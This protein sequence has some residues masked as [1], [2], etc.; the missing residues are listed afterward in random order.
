MSQVLQDVRGL[1]AEAKAVH[2]DPGGAA[3]CGDIVPNMDY[4]TMALIALDCDAMRSPP[5][6]MALITSG[7]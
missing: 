7:L 3:R 6:Q 1:A 4:D 2:S 5:H